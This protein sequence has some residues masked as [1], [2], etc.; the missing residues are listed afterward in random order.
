MVFI[1]IMAANIEIRKR[2]VAIFVTGYTH[3]FLGWPDGDKVSI[4]FSKSKI[5]VF[6]V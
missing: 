6:I 4:L 2:V 1:K 3:Q 5:F